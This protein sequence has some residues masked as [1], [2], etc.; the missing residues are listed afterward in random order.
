MAPGIGCPF[1]EGRNGVQLTKLDEQ[2][3]WLLPV[4]D[5]QKKETW[6]RNQD[7]KLAPK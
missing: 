3:S 1:S 7:Q 4:K 2:G 5:S 6:Q